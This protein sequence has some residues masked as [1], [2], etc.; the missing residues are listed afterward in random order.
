MRALRSLR[1]MAGVA[2]ADDGGVGLLSDVVLG[3]LDGD[4]PADGGSVGL[5]L[6]RAIGVGAPHAISTVR[7]QSAGRVTGAADRRARSG[8]LRRRASPRA[9]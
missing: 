3:V 8:A 6:V 7:S 4:E 9:L 1:A 2:G 5:A